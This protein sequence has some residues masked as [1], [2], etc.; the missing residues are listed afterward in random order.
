MFYS[1]P[2]KTDSRVTEDHIARELLTGA[3][4]WNVTELLDAINLVIKRVASRT[5]ASRVGASISPSEI[6]VEGIYGYL[7]V[8]LY[9][10]TQADGSKVLVLMTF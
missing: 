9:E 5:G 7:D 3:S 1:A 8:R 10:E 6:R 4:A 2:G